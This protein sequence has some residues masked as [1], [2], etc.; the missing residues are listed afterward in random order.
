MDLRIVLRDLLAVP[1][2][3]WRFTAGQDRIGRHAIRIDEH[4]MAADQGDTYPMDSPSM[5]TEMPP[6]LGD[7]GAAQERK[8]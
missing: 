5:V 4:C 3:H 6:M 8:P 1:E 7:C 2:D